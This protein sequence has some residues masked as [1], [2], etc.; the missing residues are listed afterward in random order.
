MPAL[1]ISEMRPTTPGMSDDSTLA[2]EA[3]AGAMA[4]AAARG[5]LPA[6]SG[7]ASLRAPGG[8][9]VTRSGRDKGALS[10]E[11]FLRLDAQGTPL[12]EGIPSAEAVFHA[13]IYATRP[14]AQVVLHAH[15]PAVT[16]LT[17]L[18]EAGW[19]RLEGFELLKAFPGVSTHAHALELPLFE[20]TQAMEELARLA[21]PTLQVL[22]PSQCAFL[23]RGHGA[24]VWHADA[25]A[26]FF[27]LEALETLCDYTLRL[28][29]CVGRTR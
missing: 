14:E 23:L 28:R 9:W 10:A 12:E 8:L 5:W 29:A 27:A 3:V 18:W 7:N 24:Y 16:V 21:E 6:T 15:C 11:D 25:E 20:N 22:R 2:R 19:L 13:C 1:A 4:R 17:R 26:A